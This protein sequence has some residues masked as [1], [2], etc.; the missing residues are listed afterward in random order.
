MRIC[1]YAD[2]C[3]FEPPNKDELKLHDTLQEEFSEI[4][5]WLLDNKL[6]LHV[7]KTEFMVFGSK[8]RLH[9]KRLTCISLGGQ[10]FHAK[11]S[12]TY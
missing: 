8:P 5:D 4:R 10:L 3:W 1:L 2:D 7:A 11:P 9:K 6:S 12:V